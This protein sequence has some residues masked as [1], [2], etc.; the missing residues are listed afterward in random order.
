[1][2]NI[3]QENEGN[4]ATRA[5]RRGKTALWEEARATSQKEIIEAEDRLAD[6]PLISDGLLTIDRSMMGW[7]GEG[8]I[9]KYSWRR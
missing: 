8:T 9:W 6:L 7:S 5:E 4:G 3:H 2:A 1:M